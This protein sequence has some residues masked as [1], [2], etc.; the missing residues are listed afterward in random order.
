MF[1]FLHEITLEQANELAI[2]VGLLLVAVWGI[3]Q[4]IKLVK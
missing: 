1:G 2:A 4:L 3:K